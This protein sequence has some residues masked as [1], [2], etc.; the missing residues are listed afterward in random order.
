MEVRLLALNNY[1]VD[2]ILF[3]EID[4]SLIDI[5]CRWSN[6][7]IVIL[8][9]FTMIKK[10]GIDF[11]DL[12]LE[13]YGNINELYKQHSQLHA[14]ETLFGDWN[15]EIMVLAQDAANFNTFKKIKFNDDKNNPFRHTPN[16][17][18]NINLY[19]VLKSLNRYNLGSYEQPNNKN[20]GIYYA[21]AIWLLKDSKDM[22]GAI[23][24]TKDSYV[25][26]GKV[27]EA[28]LDN[29][30]NLKIIL[31]LG[32]H[33]FNFVKQ[34]FNDQI[35]FDWHQTVNDR[36]IHSVNYKVSTYFVCSIYHTSIRGMVARSKLNN[37]LGLGALEKGL[38]ITKNDLKIIYNSINLWLYKK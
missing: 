13:G 32:R 31:T 10:F 9:E 15:A 2:I 34:F 26:N 1:I 33:S 30:S 28:T 24:N 25:L 22:S 6:D 29:L 23:T 4:N 37:F 27:F 17:R 5:N 19:E 16:N 14:C 38:E 36:K 12:N 11:A 35:I 18:T 20:C 21:N 8:W 3:T 7:E